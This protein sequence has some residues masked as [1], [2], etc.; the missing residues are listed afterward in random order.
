MF[1]VCVVCLVCAQLIRVC[2]RTVLYYTEFKRMGI[3]LLC[4]WCV[5][6]CCTEFMRQCVCVCASVASV[7]AC[8]R[9][10]IS[11]PS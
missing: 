2:V 8:M 1:G 10:S 9:T 3:R 7:C 4:V 6:A 11:V 5:C